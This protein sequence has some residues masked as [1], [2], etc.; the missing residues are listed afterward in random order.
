MALVAGMRI[1]DSTRLVGVSAFTIGIFLLGALYLV[2]LFI[3]WRERSPR[4]LLYAA[5]LAYLGFFVLP[6][7]IHER[8]LY[9][10]LAL[11]TPLA[12][13]SWA[14]ITM[15]ATLT[16]TL[17]ANQIMAL[18]YLDH[19][20]TLAEHDP[21]AIAIACVNLLALAMAIAYGV[22]LVSNDHTRW[23]RLLRALFEPPQRHEDVPAKSKQSAF[24]IATDRFRSKP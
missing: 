14:T 24:A 12:L 10:A 9:F 6:T 7:R 23:P 5:F 19:L 17:L 16:V 20:T 13:D 21:Y 8:Y 4:A 2:S 1:P 22:F 18:R 3:V 11:L 15:F